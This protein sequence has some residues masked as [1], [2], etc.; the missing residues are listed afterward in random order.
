MTATP[1]TSMERVLCTLSQKEPDRVPLF[2]LLSLHGARELGLGLEEYFSD[3]DHI[4]EAQIR[5]QRKYRVDCYNPF[6]YASLEIEA[7]GGETEFREDG[8]A[9]AG[10]PIIGDVAEIATLEPPRVDDSPGL[11]K[12]LSAVRRL[13]EHAAGA[14]PVI[15]AVISPFSLPVMQLGFERYLKLIYE[16]RDLFWELMAVNEAFATAWGNAQLAAGATAVAYFDPVSSPSILPSQLS[17]ELG[18]PIAAR[19][20]GG[21]EGAVGI[22]FASGRCLPVI[23]DVVAAGAGTGRCELR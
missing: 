5:V 9:N 16:Q 7:F 14:I 3:P 20:I 22:H 17:R 23:D 10:A 11:Q 19:M 8:P 15:G 4:V 18:F 12:A 21:L 6:M 2:L 1:M 13:A